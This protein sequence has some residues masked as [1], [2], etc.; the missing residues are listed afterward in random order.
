MVF[1]CLRAYKAVKQEADDQHA[2]AY[3]V[4]RFSF[5][6]LHLARVEDD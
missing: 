6:T 2:D 4:S 5:K 3:R 1:I